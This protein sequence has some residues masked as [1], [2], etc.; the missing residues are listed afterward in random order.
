MIEESPAILEFS[1]CEFLV[2]IIHSTPSYVA[3][4]EK[5]MDLAQF[6]K[7]TTN[8]SN[9]CIRGYTQQDPPRIIGDADI[10]VWRKSSRQTAH[11]KRKVSRCDL[12]K[13]ELASRC[14]SLGIP[15]LPQLLDI[16]VVTNTPNAEEAIKCHPSFTTTD[17]YVLHNLLYGEMS[18]K[19]V[20]KLVKIISKRSLVIA[21]RIVSA[22]DRRHR[23]RM[24]PLPA[25]YEIAQ[26]KFSNISRHMCIMCYSFNFMTTRKAN[27][28]PQ[29]ACKHFE[30]SSYEG[31]RKVCVK[32]K[33]EPDGVPLTA[34]NMIGYAVETPVGTFILCCEC[35]TATDVRCGLRGSSRAPFICM[36]CIKNQPAMALGGEICC[37]CDMLADP[38][39]WT[40]ETGTPF[41]CADCI[42]YGF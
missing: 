25:R 41:K 40:P 24:I 21:T 35:N 8:V 2:V 34:I 32:C 36:R 14:T 33:S 37:F 42:A 31:F 27:K 30:I 29:K 26:A 11:Q 10:A 38:G 6:T 22:L 4:M 9:F 18:T 28:N 12:L 15:T 13:K 17:V 5:Y 1:I 23:V 19:V 39:S 16:F 3:V 20:T 7:Y